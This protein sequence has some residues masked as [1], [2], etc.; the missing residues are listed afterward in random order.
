MRS[1]TRLLV[2]AL[3]GQS[4][5]ANTTGDAAPDPDPRPNIV[6]LV[7]EDMSPWIGCW[8]DDTVPTPNIDRL[9]AEGI[10]YTNAFATTPVCAPSRSALITGMYPTRIGSMHMR[11]GSRSSAATDRNPDAYGDT[12]LYEAVPPEFV[13]CFPEILR[14][15]GY[16]CT[17]ASKTDYQFD[18]PPT[19]WDDSSGRAHWRSRPD[20]APFFAV[21]NAGVTHESQAFPDANARPVVVTPEDVPL[22]PFYPDTP[23]ARDAMA[24]TYNN[25]AALDRWVGDRLDELEKAGLL[26][27]TIVFFY[28]DHGVGLP[29]G[30]RDLYDT[31]V[32]IPLIV[33]F[34]DRRDAGTVEPRLVSFIDFGPTVLSLA[35]IE[36]DPRLDGRAFLGA[37]EGERRSF[38][39]VHADRMDAVRDTKRGVSDGRYKYIRNLTPDRPLIGPNAY[40]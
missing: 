8:G 28:T 40:R 20:G 29:R 9:A 32:R 24:R 30:K 38:A 14:T 36:P 25:I 12:P 6:W 22:P 31:G 5:F 11:T 2:L 1:I 35:G 3:F 27:S 16:H 7:A 21:F 39:F 26:Q 34:P 17:N 19:V 4:L 33:R 10:R 23:A 15:H 13:R 18:A 37:F